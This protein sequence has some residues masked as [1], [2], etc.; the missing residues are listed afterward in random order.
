MGNNALRE[1]FKFTMSQ[2]ELKKQLVNTYEQFS[3]ASHVETQE[4]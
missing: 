2:V 4:K 1:A 3:R